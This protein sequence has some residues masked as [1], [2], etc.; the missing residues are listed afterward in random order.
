MQVW[1]TQCYETNYPQASF[2]VWLRGLVTDLKDKVRLQALGSR[3]L[4]QIDRCHENKQDEKHQD[5]RGVECNI[6]IEGDLEEQV[7]MAWTC[8]TEGG[9][10]I[11][12]ST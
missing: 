11:R 3:I 6:F 9:G 4:R 2:T 1:S 5:Q 10:D 7:Q 8:D 12:S